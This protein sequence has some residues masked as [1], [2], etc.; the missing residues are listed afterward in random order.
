MPLLPVSERHLVNENGAMALAAI[1]IL[2]FSKLLHEIISFSS[3]FL[4]WIFL[5]FYVIFCS[6]F[7]II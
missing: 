7:D 6:G 1:D 5:M 2:L 4:F 3:H